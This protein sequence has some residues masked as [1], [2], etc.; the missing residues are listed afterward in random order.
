MTVLVVIWSSR[1]R[2]GPMM[3]TSKRFS[4]AWIFSVRSWTTLSTGGRCARPPDARPPSTPRPVLPL[5]AR[6]A[7]RARRSSILHVCL[8]REP[9]AAT[10][11]CKLHSLNCRAKR[12]AAECAA[13]G[14]MPC[15]G[16]PR[17][18][19]ARSAPTSRRS[20]CDS[21]RRGRAGRTP[22]ALRSIPC[23]LR[24][25]QH[26][27][28]CRF[29]GAGAAA[30]GQ[31]CGGGIP[32]Q[33]SGGQ[34]RASARRAHAGIRRGRRSRPGARRAG[35]G[36]RAARAHVGGGRVARLVRGLVRQVRVH[37][38]LGA[39]ALD[40]GRRAVRAEHVRQ[41][42]AHLA[43]RA[44]GQPRLGSARPRAAPLAGGAAAAAQRPDGLASGCWTAVTR[45]LVFWCTAV[46]GCSPM[47]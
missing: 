13:H 43:R 26:M 45:M 7:R 10:R 27:A 19:R 29:G 18:R 25:E 31:W 39:V 33:G 8:S 3:T 38:Q 46:S 17:E 24:A 28:L 34:D 21:A 11:R 16:V 35:S 20:A 12:R 40:D 2:P 5:R 15:A 23:A 1:P 4:H 6:H 42:G 22:H 36:R 47:A 9:R 32:E 14:R 37:D 44:P 30:R 41:V